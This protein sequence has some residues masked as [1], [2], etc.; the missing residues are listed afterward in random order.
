MSSFL[1]T[2]AGVEPR[3]HPSLR[4]WEN[5]SGLTSTVAEPPAT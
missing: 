3:A 5:L 4:L 2:I 1:V